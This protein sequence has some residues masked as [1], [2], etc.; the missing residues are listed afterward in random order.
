MSVH[1]GDVAR[2]T[3]QIRRKRYMESRAPDS[4]ISVVHESAGKELERAWKDATAEAAARSSLL[5]CWPRE[6]SQISVQ[7]WGRDGMEGDQKL[8]AQ[9]DWEALG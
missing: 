1:A 4:S 7:V 6:Y 2:H 3:K 9:S 8:L 5:Q